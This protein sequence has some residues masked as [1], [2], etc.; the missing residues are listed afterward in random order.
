[1]VAVPTVGVACMFLGLFSS[2][3]DSGWCVLYGPNPTLPSQACSVLNPSSEEKVLLWSLHSNPGDSFLVFL[4]LCRLFCLVLFSSQQSPKQVQS[5]QRLVTCAL[6]W[7][8]LSP[9]PLRMPAGR[10]FLNSA[11]GSASES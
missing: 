4:P 8:K 9:G 7:D 5:F 3:T 2:G 10:P 1:M 6:I 11:F